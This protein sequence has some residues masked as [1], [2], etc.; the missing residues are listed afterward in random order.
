MNKITKEI[1][2]I[3]SQ[4]T[5]DDCEYIDLLDRYH[6]LVIKLDQVF[7]ECGAVCYDKKCDKT[8]TEKEYKEDMSNW[9]IDHATGYY[10][11]SDCK[12][13]LSVAEE[14]NDTMNNHDINIDFEYCVDSA[15]MLIDTYKSYKKIKEKK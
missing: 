14:I 12:K 7:G 2:A 15:Y 10:F 5:N 13:Y 9:S 4:L 6:E 8:Y 1:N 3:R 11:C